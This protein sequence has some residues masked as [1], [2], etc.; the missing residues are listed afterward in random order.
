MV[1]RWPNAMVCWTSC[2]PYSILYLATVALLPHQSM[3]PLL[4]ADPACLVNISL[5][6]AVTT[7]MMLQASANIKGMRRLITLPLSQ[8][9]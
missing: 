4:Q 5:L 3:Q 1:A 2:F 9:A 7:N 6:H 8:T